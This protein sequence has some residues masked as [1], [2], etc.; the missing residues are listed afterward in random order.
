MLFP[1]GF[2]CRHAHPGISQQTEGGLAGLVIL[3]S[4]APKETPVEQEKSCKAGQRQR[5]RSRRKLLMQHSTCS[6]KQG[7][8]S[9]LVAKGAAGT[10]ASMGYSCE[11]V[12]GGDKSFAEP[13]KW[14]NYFPPWCSDL[15]AFGSAI[16]WR[17]A[18]LQLR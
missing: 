7:E 12:P 13:L 8:K 18:L 4:S 10:Y 11:M 14:L 2:H 17:E 6:K 16:D 1:F 15:T 5:R 9:K 3:P